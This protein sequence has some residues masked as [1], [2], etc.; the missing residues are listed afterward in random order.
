MSHEKL[1]N[2]NSIMAFRSCEHT[3]ILPFHIH[4]R[5]SHINGPEIMYDIIKD[6]ISK[7]QVG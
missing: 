5:D 7:N 4:S 1:E 6:K 2:N 3:V